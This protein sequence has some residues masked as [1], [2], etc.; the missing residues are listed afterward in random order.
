MSPGPNEKT[1]NVSH[2]KKL[3]KKIL[4]L[5]AGVTHDE[6]GNQVAADSSI[7]QQQQQ[8]QHQED[9]SYL[10]QEQQQQQQLH[11]QQQMQQ[12]Q[13]QNDM[14]DSQQQQMINQD[15]FQMEQTLPQQ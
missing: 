6:Y 7:G 3:L 13:Q 10:Q 4:S 12:Q 11:D 5:F 9:Q 15:N 14:Y 1:I 2:N 8:Q